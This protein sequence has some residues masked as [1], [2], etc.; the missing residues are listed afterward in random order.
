MTFKMQPN[1]EYKLQGYRVQ[2]ARI[3]V[4]SSVKK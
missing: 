1:L 3:K 2:T 4:V